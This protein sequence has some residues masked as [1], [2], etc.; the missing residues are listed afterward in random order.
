M[1]LV[2][3]FQEEKFL[4]WETSRGWASVWSENSI[5]K[6]RARA[7]KTS[8][9]FFSF[10]GESEVSRKQK[11]L[12][13][14]SIS[15][16]FKSNFSCNLRV[17]ER[18]H[19]RKAFSVNS[20]KLWE[21]MIQIYWFSAILRCLGMFKV[22]RKKF[23]WLRD[24]RKFIAGVGFTKYCRDNCANAGIRGWVKNSKRGTIVGKMQGLKPEIDKM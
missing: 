5:G 14:A 8:R 24:S 18:W 11:S 2:L 19:N 23:E 6:Y 4:N 9:T 16:S 20:T 12:V 22:G 3:Y 1:R 7:R 13:G 21:W 17:I 10:A 15:F